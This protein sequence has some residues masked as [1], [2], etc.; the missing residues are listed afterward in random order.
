MAAQTP[1]VHDSWVGDVWNT[2][3]PRKKVWFSVWDFPS[4]VLPKIDTTLR[5]SSGLQSSR[6]TKSSSSFNYR[7][8]TTE[9]EVS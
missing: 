6:L 5:S 9:P 2:S 3:R 8:K 7:G 1:T 4:P